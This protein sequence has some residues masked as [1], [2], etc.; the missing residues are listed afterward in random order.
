MISRG[1]GLSRT[2]KA[3]VGVRRPICVRYH[4]LAADYDGTLAHDGIVDDKTVAMLDRLKESGRKLVMVTGRELDD[5]FK[6]FD[7][8]DKFD[9]IVA[10]NGA[11]VYDPATKKETKLAE[12]PPPEFAARLREKGATPFSEGRVIV[13][14]REPWQQLVLDTIQEFGLELQVIFNKGAVMVLPS[15]V[16]KATG[17]KC[18]LEDL[19]YSPHNT[20]AVGDAENDHAF[21]SICECS[22]AVA[23][24]LDSVKN[25]ADF[26]TKGARGHGVQ[27]LI[28]GMLKDDLDSIAPKLSRHDISIGAD[29]NG[30][31]VCI[32]VSGSTVLLAGGSGGGKSTLTTG[33]ME[34]M[35]HAG[36]QLCAVDPEGDYQTFPNAVIIGD[37]QAAPSVDQV[38]T[39]L[40]KPTISIVVNL[41]AIPF[42]ERPQFFNSLMS[43]LHKLRDATGRPHWIII[44]EAHHVIPESHE[45]LDD[46]IS[47]DN[48]FLITLDPKR[49][50]RDH[51]AAVSHVIAVG[52]NPEEIVK[53]FCAE[54]GQDCPKFEHSELKHREALLWRCGSKESPMK[55]KVEES[56]TPR[57]RHSRKYAT[58]ELTPDRSFYF[59]GPEEKLN[60][61]ASNLSDFVRLLEGVDDETWQF[62]LEKGEYSKWFRDNIK[63]EELADAAGRIE[64]ESNAPAQDS[65]AAIRSEIEQRYALPA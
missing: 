30:N 3:I 26:V 19:G 50:H 33:F 27:E 29:E 58:A 22:V 34:R 24:A 9:R 7:H 43:E 38:V 4:V 53:S 1:I 36:Y 14:T 21:L 64:T 2:V 23:N 20:V 10:E 15:G 54:C 8:T 5:L 46:H 6:T 49:I 13:A 12:T 16:N 25:R 44:D 11:L 39:A 55:F 48:T 47:L 51:H 62:H 40:R 35:A 31:Q 32:P 41:L 60:L 42:D 59:R 57:V 45:P 63:N 52:D 56:E 37:G 65:R 18:A 17:L 28:Q 61:R